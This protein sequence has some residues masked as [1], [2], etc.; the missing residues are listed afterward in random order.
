LLNN[1]GR[2]EDVEAELRKAIAEYPDSN[3]YRYSL[4]NFQRDRGDLDTTLW[5]SLPH[6]G[7]ESLLLQLLTLGHDPEALDALLDLEHPFR[8]AAERVLRDAAG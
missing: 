7:A 4:A 5:R 1:L 6:F 2:A 3:E 8:T